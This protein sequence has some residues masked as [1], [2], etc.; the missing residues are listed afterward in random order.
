MTWHGEEKVVDFD[1]MSAQRRAAMRF[2]WAS[3]SKEDEPV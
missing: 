3:E 1:K 2:D